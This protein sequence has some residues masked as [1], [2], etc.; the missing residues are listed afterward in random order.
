MFAPLAETSNSAYVNMIFK[1][2][3]VLGPSVQREIVL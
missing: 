2:Q 1:D 3:I